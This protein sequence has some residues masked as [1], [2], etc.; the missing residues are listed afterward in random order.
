MEFLK[1][2][3][4]IGVVWG[5]W[6]VV[7]NVLWPATVLA[8]GVPLA[9]YILLSSISILIAQLPAFRVLMVW[10]YDRTQSLLL[11]M[12]AH[13]SLVFSTFVLGPVGI[14]GIA[15]LTYGFAIG[16]G[17]WLLVGSSTCGQRRAHQTAACNAALILRDH[18]RD[19]A[20]GA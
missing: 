2:G 14:D 18:T 20:L 11:V 17:M 5:A 10:L 19:V 12:L 13:A 4:G 3:I 1:T 9:T 15:I 8:H 7:T 6:H 16:L